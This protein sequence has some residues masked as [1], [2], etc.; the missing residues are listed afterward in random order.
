MQLKVFSTTKSIFFIKIL[1]SNSSSYFEYI[2][3]ILGDNLEHRGE[4]VK[5]ALIEL[6][7]TQ[8]AEYPSGM[9]F[10]H[11]PIV[12]WLILFLSDGLI[13]KNIISPRMNPEIL[14]ESSW[15]HFPHDMKHSHCFKMYAFM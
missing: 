8:S 10:I 7:C 15:N 9:I 1:R 3:S 2:P 5:K 6:N 14:S 11:F 12:W 4:K 13:W